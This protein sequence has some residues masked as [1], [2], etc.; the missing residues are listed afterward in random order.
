MITFIIVLIGFLMAI[1][2]GYCRT[3]L[4]QSPSFQIFLV[5][6]I[7]VTAWPVETPGWAGLPILCILARLLTVLNFTGVRK[8]ILS[9]PIFKLIR[10]LLPPVS[11]VEKE[12]LEVRAVRRD[13][14]IFASHLSDWKKLLDSPPGQFCEE[15]E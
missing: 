4:R 15:V 13:A 2:F 14:E 1:H 6:F 3:S 5:S 10:K 8:A 12:A 11:M 7:T 9:D